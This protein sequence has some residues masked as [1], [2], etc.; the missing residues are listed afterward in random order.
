MLRSI[1]NEVFHS[2]H[3]IVKQGSP[4][5]QL[6]ES[7]YLSSNSCPDLCLTVLEKLNKCRNKISCNDLI[8][9]SFCDLA[10]ISTGYISCTDP[11]LTFSNLSATIY[12]T[13]QLLSSIKLLKD[14]SK[15]P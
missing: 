8:I 1:G 14:V 6:A 5:N 2:G 10:T 15:T 9:Y 4:V 11:L 13:L 3:D 12:R 7:R